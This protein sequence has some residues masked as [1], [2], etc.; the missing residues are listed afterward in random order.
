MCGN[1]VWLYLGEGK[2]AGRVADNCKRGHSWFCQSFLGD[3]QRLQT[4]RVYDLIGIH[5]ATLGLGVLGNPQGQQPECACRKPNELRP[6]LH[7]LRRQCA[8]K[9]AGKKIPQLRSDRAN[10]ATPLLVK[11]TIFLLLCLELG[12]VFQKPDLL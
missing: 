9:R 1:H 4:R 11:P 6:W 7:S 12:I 8:V 10:S 5:Q 3:C 2:S